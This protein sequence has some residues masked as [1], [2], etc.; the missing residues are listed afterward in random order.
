MHT[1][2]NNAVLTSSLSE[3]LRPT[4]ISSIF[5]KDWRNDRSDHKT[6]SIF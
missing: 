1:N 3:Q 5:E 4:K 2:L 6:V